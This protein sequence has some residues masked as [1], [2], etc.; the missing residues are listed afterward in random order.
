MPKHGKNE[1][2]KPAV[3]EENSFSCRAFFPSLPVG[4]F[5]AGSVSLQQWLACAGGHGRGALA[6]CYEDCHLAL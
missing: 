4:L 6:R 3:F 5:K 1:N 2:S